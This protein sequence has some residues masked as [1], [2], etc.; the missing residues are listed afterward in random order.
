MVGFMMLR[1]WR[2]ALV[3]VL[4]LAALISCSSG[5]VN[6]PSPTKA[7]VDYVALER[8]IEDRIANG[9]VSLDN[10]RAVLVNVDGQTKVEDYRHG[11]SPESTTHVWSVTKSVVSTLIGIAIADGIVGGLDDTARGSDG[12]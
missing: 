1:G 6:D 5:R 12:I 7:P 10:I 11:A 9:S 3:A 4:S 2:Q 8:A